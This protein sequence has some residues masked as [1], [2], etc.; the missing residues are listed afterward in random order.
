MQGRSFLDFEHFLKNLSHEPCQES[1]HLP[2]LQTLFRL[3][4]N[5]K[6]LRITII[7]RNYVKQNRMQSVDCDAAFAQIFARTFASLAA[8]EKRILTQFMQFALQILLIQTIKVASKVIQSQK[9]VDL[10]HHF[11]SHFLKNLYYSLVE[12]SKNASC[13][14]KFALLQLLLQKL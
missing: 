9:A 5:Q 13:N 6:A 12:K 11:I 7:I 2:P 1:L 10:S 4:N 14:L 8:M 3:H